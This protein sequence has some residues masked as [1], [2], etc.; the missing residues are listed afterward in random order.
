MIFSRRESMKLVNY[1]EDLVLHVAEI[2]LQDRPDVEFSQALLLDTAAYTLNR[3]PPRY[4]VSERGFTRLMANLWIEEGDDGNI[5]GL[6]A[7]LLLVNTAVDVVKDR[8]PS[9]GDETAG[10]S[11]FEAEDHIEPHWHNIPYLIGR[12]VDSETGQPASGTK[13]T[14]TVDGETVDQAGSGWTNPY[15]TNSATRGFYSFL[16]KPIHS[17]E[18]SIEFKLEIVFENGG[19]ETH[20]LEKTVRTQGEL[21]ARLEFRNEGFINLGTTSLRKS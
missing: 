12:A 4:I 16:P 1:Q 14:L 3:L 10:S 17:E 18:H 11:D 19:C 21:S 5:D 15:V 8:R 20:R 13:V 9:G 7:I 6:V 2:V